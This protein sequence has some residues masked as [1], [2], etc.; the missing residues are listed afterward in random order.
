LATVPEAFEKWMSATVT[1]QP[2]AVFPLALIA[3]F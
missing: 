2:V 1:V 3:R